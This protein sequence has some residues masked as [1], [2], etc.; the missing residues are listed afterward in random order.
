MASSAPAISLAGLFAGD[1]ERMNGTGPF[2]SWVPRPGGGGDNPPV[3]WG[4]A[5]TVATGSW[6]IDKSMASPVPVS[7]GMSATFGPCVCVPDSM[8]SLV[9]GDVVVVRS[10]D[11]LS[12]MVSN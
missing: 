10:T 8:A 2:K 4:A 3:G 12:G 7:A 11:F 6:S 1:W 5:V 9:C